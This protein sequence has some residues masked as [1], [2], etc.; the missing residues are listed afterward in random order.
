MLRTRDEVTNDFIS[1]SSVNSFFVSSQ[2]CVKLWDKLTLRLHGVA[3]F[4][5]CTHIFV[6]VELEIFDQHSA[7]I[8]TDAYRSKVKF[9]FIVSSL[10][11]LLRIQHTIKLYSKQEMPFCSLAFRI[12][13]AVVCLNIFHDRT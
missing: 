13:A 4:V 11:P 5:L 12:A 1:G 6:L 2:T 7:S 8:R 10:S 3:Q 9:N